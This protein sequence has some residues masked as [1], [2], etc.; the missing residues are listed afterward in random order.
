[1]WNVKGVMLLVGSFT[2]VQGKTGLIYFM[3][4]NGSL[5][6]KMRMAM[7]FEERTSKQS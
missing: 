5:G 7:L 4:G 6:N 3:L 1:M 2:K